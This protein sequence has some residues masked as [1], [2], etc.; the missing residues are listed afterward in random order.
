MDQAVR[1]KRSRRFERPATPQGMRLTERDIRI[2]GWVAKHRF[3]SS[4]QLALLDGGSAQNLLRCLKVLFENGYLDRPKAQLADALAAGNRPMVYGV[5]RKGARVLRELGSSIDPDL[6]WSDK[7]R[8]AGT[9]FV[10]HTVAVADVLVRFEVACRGRDDVTF[11]D[12]ADILAHAPE[13]TRLAREPLRWVAEIA[14]GGELITASVV[15]DALFGLAFADGTASYF[16][17]EVDRGTM[18]VVRKGTSRTSFARKLQVY[19]EGWKQG[20]HTAQFGVKQVRMMTVTT[21]PQRVATMIAATKAITGGAGSNI[22]LFA[23]LSVLHQEALVRRD[24]R[25]GKGD[26]ISLVP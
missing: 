23:D 25:T 26:S 17:L 14:E 24:W 13:K 8:K 18:P 3:L 22:F 1:Q 2:L 11:L 12:A 16:L 6:D 4:A 10:A 5:T 19:W 21:S 15:P 9:T 7:N 20:R